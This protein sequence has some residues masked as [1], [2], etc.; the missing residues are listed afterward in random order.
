[1]LARTWKQDMV[2]DKVVKPAPAATQIKAVPTNNPPRA[3]A[4]RNN[5]DG[6]KKREECAWC[7]ANGL[8]ADHPERL[9]WSNPASLH[10][11]EDIAQWRLAARD[12]KK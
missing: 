11:R 4:G 12:R 8:H 10:Y 7:K 2:E 3:P 6:D 1:M 9:C 5:F